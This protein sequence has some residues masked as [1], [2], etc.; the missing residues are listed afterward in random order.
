MFFGTSNT[1]T[2]ARSDADGADGGVGSA[3]DIGSA[4]GGGGQ[5]AVA[6]VELGQLGVVGPARAAGHEVGALLRLGEGDD[7]AQAV[8]AAHQHAEAVE[9]EGDAAVGRR[10]VAEGVEQEAE[11][12]LDL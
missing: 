10:A 6:D 5:V 12:L 9:A 7:V 8:G 3:S 4:L 1:A 2:A 11:L